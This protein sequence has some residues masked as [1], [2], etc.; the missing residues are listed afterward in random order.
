[1]SGIGRI[2]GGRRERGGREGREA[3]DAKRQASQ[4][5]D[6]S[7]EKSAEHESVQRPAAMA[8]WT[9][10][11]CHLQ[12]IDTDDE[13]RAVLARA[14][15]VGTRRV[16]VVGTDAPSSRRA[17]D[18]ASMPAQDGPGS[19]EVW[20][21]VGLHPHD[22]SMGTAAVRNFLEE[23]SAQG[24][25]ASRVVG[26]G[27]CGLD[28]H[29]DHSPWPAQ[30]RAFAEQVRMAHE[31]G[32]ALVVHTREAWEDTFA[33]LESEGVPQRT[34][35]HCFTGG[36]GEAE[37]CLTLGAYLSF[38]GIV[39]FATAEELCAAAALTPLDR[40]LIETDSPFLTPVPYRGK[41]NEP[42]YVPVVGEAMARLKGEDPG[43]LARAT[44]AN[45]SVV[46]DLH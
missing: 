4:E 40:M 16:V 37:R 43:E 35:F 29:Y 3:R 33:I 1:M 7:A 14:E 23:V 46:F 15:E 42:C 34:I 19:T 11:H 27:E 6:S 25:S 26:V 31:L 22:S 2:F 36:P 39:T 28:F 24:F 44:S 18:I 13:V 21:T 10:S 38:S 17:V 8:L 30:R 32:L 5:V 41:P 12:H 45:A 20:A 9:D